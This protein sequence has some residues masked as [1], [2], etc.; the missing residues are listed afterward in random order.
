M[1][2]YRSTATETGGAVIRTV[3]GA[4][5][6]NDNA[7]RDRVE[8]QEW[9]ED[10]GVPDPYVKPEPVPPQATEGQA[11]AFDHENRIRELEGQP[12]LTLEDFGK[13]LQGDG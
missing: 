12:P 5:I 6:P 7:N 1:A 10:G 8:Y 3:D 11:L 9:L 2:D 4:F 13:K